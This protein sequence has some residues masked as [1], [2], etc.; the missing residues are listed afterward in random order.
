MGALAALQEEHI[1]HAVETPA[2]TDED[3]ARLRRYNVLVSIALMVVCNVVFLG[4][5]W[6]TGLKMDTLVRIPEIFNPTR[7][8]CLRFI[9]RP[10]EGGD[11]PA[12]VCSEWI[13]LSDPSGNTHKIQ[14]ETEVVKGGDGRLYFEHGARVDYRLFVFIAF[15]VAIIVVGVRTKRYLLARYRRQLIDRHSSFDLSSQS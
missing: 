4:G 3:A 12:R 1:R 2:L 9:W 10:V 8:V 7:D 5:L 11:Q 14:K 13:N 15:V 6:V